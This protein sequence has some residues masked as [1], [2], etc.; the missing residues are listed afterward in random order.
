MYFEE[1]HYTWNVIVDHKATLDKTRMH[2]VAAIEDKEKG[3][4]PRK[5]YL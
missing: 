1:I 3:Q 4:M 2:Y 5:E